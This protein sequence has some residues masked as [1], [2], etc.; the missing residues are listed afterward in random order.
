[1]A[2]M[3]EHPLHAA[4]AY[5]RDR[6]AAAEEALNTRPADDQAALDQYLHAKQALDY[7]IKAVKADQGL[8]VQGPRTFAWHQRG[9]R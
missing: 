6:Y 2:T 8:P 9:A 4:Y 1:M 5:A 7:A 3:T